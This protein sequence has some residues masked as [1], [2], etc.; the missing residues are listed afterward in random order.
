MADLRNLGQA[1]QRFGAD[2]NVALSGAVAKAGA[3]ITSAVAAETPVLTSRCQSNWQMSEN[4]QGA[5]YFFDPPVSDIRPGNKRG[6]A[7]NKVKRDARREADRLFRSRKLIVGKRMRPIYI[8]N[9]T[10]YLRFLNNGRSNQ[11]PRGFIQKESKKELRR[12]RRDFARIMM[13]IFREV[14]RSG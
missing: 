1:L 9:P 3:S 2:L 14:R 10:P 7:F 11:A 5:R 8:H 6:P 13:D 12:Q 4:K